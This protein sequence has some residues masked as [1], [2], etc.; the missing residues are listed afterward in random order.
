MEPGK[1]KRVLR[2]VSE[3]T[4]ACGD[5][6]MQFDTTINDW[7]TRPASG[8][9]NGS[10]PCFPGDARVHTT[11]GL[12]PIAEL[13]ERTKAGED[14]A[15]YTHRATAP[16]AADGVV[17]SLPLAVMRNGTSAIVRLRFS[18]G[19]ELRCTPNHRIWTKRGWVEAHSLTTDHQGLPTPLPPPPEE[20][21]SP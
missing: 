19:A 16:V 1:A 7:H 20:P 6:G 11:A 8:R 9:I 3:A 12:L 14:I 10:N 5:P 17:S 21:S 15:V 13:F 4:G 18:N 2:E